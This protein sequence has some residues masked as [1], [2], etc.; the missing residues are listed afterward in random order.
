MLLVVC[1]VCCVW[2]VCFGLVDLNVGLFDWVWVCLV[3]RLLWMFVVLLWFL[4]GFV[5]LGFYC[6]DLFV[7]V[8]LFG[9]YFVLLLCGVCDCVFVVWLV[10]LL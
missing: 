10:G 8:D 9:V 1:F 4:M 6:L 2:F 7:G 3:A 5:L